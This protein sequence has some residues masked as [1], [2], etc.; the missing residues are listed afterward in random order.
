MVANHEVNLK[1]LYE[2]ALPK[3]RRSLIERGKCQGQPER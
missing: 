3:G 1:L 2:K